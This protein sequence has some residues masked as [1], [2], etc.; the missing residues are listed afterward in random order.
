MSFLY[1]ADPLARTLQ[2]AEGDL[3]TLLAN[4]CSDKN[5]LLIC[6]HSM[7]RLGR[8]KCSSATATWAGHG[9]RVREL[10]RFLLFLDHLLS[11]HLYGV[12]S[13]SEW[14]KGKMKPHQQ[15]PIAVILMV[16]TIRNA[17]TS[18]KGMQG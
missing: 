3:Q 6:C 14:E 11:Q 13:V 12:T 10:I 15:N 7:E 4:R 8:T 1:I 2:N 17:S 16:Q 18:K 9:R 5:S